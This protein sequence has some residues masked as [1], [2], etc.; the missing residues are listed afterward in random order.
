MARSG[1]VACAACAG[2]NSIEC[3][4]HRFEHRRMLTHPEIIV[5][6][7][8][9][10]LLSRAMIKGLRKAAGAPLKIGKDPISIFAPYELKTRLNESIK[11][12]RFPLRSSITVKSSGANRGRCRAPSIDGVPRLPRQDR[13]HS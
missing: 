12:H 2:Y 4:V 9:G 1:N 13:R 11:L 8:D 7:P 10:H 5:G 3:F 6:T